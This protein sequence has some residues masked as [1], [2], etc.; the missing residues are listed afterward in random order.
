MS[1]SASLLS[2]S[3]PRLIKEN[4]LKSDKTAPDPSEPASRFNVSTTYQKSHSP[5]SMARSVTHTCEN[6]KSISYNAT[7][8]RHQL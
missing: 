8:P 1:L 2:H 4:E 3:L 6:Y 5:R 7:D